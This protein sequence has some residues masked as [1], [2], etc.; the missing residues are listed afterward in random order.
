MPLVRWSICRTL[1]SSQ[2]INSIYSTQENVVGKKKGKGREIVQ[3]WQTQASSKMLTFWSC[4]GVVFFK[5]IQREKKCCLSSIYNVFSFK[6]IN[7]FS[8]NVS[9]MLTTLS[10]I[11]FMMEYYLFCWRFCRAVSNPVIDVG[12]LSLGIYI[13]TVLAVWI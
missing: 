4:L 1:Y 9:T 2:K 3:G 7:C 6:I 13:L 8:W 12:K 10:S 5:W 11:D